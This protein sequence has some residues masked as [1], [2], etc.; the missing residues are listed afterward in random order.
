MGEEDVIV[1][2]YSAYDSV[3]VPKTLW[4]FLSRLDGRKPWEEAASEAELDPAAG[5]KA[6]L[7]LRKRYGQIPD[8]KKRIAA[9]LKQLPADK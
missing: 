9:A 7:A 3:R 5:R 4:Q 2:G 8:F 6:Y 1:Y